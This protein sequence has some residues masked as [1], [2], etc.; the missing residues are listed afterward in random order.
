MQGMRLQGLKRTADQAGFTYSRKA[1]EKA[2]LERIA[3]R[4]IAL[5]KQ[6]DLLFQNIDNLEQLDRKQLLELFQANQ[7]ESIFD[8]FK[9]M[10]ERRDYLADALTFGLLENCP[11]CN[12]CLRLKASQY[13]C[14]GYV[15]GWERCTF[16]TIAPKRKTLSIPDAFKNQYNFLSNY[17]YKQGKKR[18]FFISQPLSSHLKLNGTKDG[19]DSGRFV[20]KCK[21]K[22]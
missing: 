12:G 2:K 21:L 14:N 8:H 11:K 10:Q 17:K 18:M 9:S 15:T 5:E 19:V 20:I 13:V 6:S 4:E 1:K 16:E 7:I 22:N 3:K